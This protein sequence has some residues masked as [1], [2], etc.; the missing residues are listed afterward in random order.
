MTIK[1][2]MLMRGF[3]TLRGS[4]LVDPNQEWSEDAPATARLRE[5]GAAEI[6]D[7][8]LNQIHAHRDRNDA[9]KRRVQRQQYRRTATATA[10]APRRRSW[11]AGCIRWAP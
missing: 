5:A 2:L 4:R 11:M 1:D 8:R 6:R 7:Q 3:P 10:R 9:T